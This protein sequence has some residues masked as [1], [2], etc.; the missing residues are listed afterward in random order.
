[1]PDDLGI[2]TRL[3]DRLPVRG[4]ALAGADVLNIVGCASTAP[5]VAGIRVHVAGSW[6]GTGTSNDGNAQ[7]T[8]GTGTTYSSLAGKT[9]VAVDAFGQVS[10]TISGKLQTVVTAGSASYSL[11]GTFQVC[12][13][14]DEIAP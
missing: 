3:A 6:P 4:R 1:V 14:P 2:V 8:D 9:V 13:V 10:Q 11:S 12:H 5:G 7:F